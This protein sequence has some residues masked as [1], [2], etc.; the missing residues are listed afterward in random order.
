MVK[1]LWS[2]DTEWSGKEKGTWEGRGGRE[3]LEGVNGGETLKKIN[4]MTK[5]SIFNKR[6]KRKRS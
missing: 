6:G 1:K 4:C 5:E 2:V 3:E